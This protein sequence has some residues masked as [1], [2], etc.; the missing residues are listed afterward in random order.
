MRLRN[1]E[2]IG[3]V[4]DAVV[5]HP[6]AASRVTKEYFESWYFEMGRIIDLRNLAQQDKKILGIPRWVYRELVKQIFCFLKTSDE[7]QKFYHKLQ[8]I[9]FFGS[10]KQKWFASH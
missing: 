5:H 9:R 6:V 3:Y 7:R 1:K 10:F 4:P 2:N 8:V